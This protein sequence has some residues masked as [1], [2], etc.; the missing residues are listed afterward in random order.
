MDGAQTGECWKER[1]RGPRVERGCE[2]NPFNW[3]LIT[4]FLLFAY[5]RSWHSCWL[6]AASAVAVWRRFLASSSALALFDPTK[7]QGFLLCVCRRQRVF[8]GTRRRAAMWLQQLSVISFVG[9]I[10]SSQPQTFLLYWHLGRFLR[11]QHLCLLHFLHILSLHRT[12]RQDTHRNSSATAALHFSFWGGE[13][14]LLYWHGIYS[15]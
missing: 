6:A 8:T 14:K 9:R 12:D 11:S 4:L 2:W 13:L 7:F 3:T 10:I 1:R 5:S 15:L